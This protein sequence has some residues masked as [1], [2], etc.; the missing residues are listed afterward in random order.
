MSEALLMNFYLIIS[1]LNN[2]TNKLYITSSKQSF[3][4][5]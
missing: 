3:L 1:I 5:K 2:W 4:G